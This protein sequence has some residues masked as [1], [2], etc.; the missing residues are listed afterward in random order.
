MQLDTIPTNSY[1]MPRSL[2][3][4]STENHFLIDGYY[5]GGITLGND[6]INALNGKVFVAKFVDNISS[7][8]NENAEPG[9]ISCF[10]N[11]A[12]DVITVNF[13]SSNASTIVSVYNLLGK[14][15]CTKSVHDQSSCV[16]SLRDQAKGLYF[17]EVQAEGGKAVKKII[18][19]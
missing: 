19:N 13:K 18:L 11:P 4:N 5:D 6:S 14:C 1:I 12:T 15:V 9:S 7:S 8:I 3:Y 17:I 16:I 2:Y 10:P